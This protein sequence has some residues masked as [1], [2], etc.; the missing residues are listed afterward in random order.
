M[1][2][3]SGFGFNFLYICVSVFTVSFYQF[4][5]SLLNKSINLFL[6]YWHQ[7][8][9][10]CP[11]LRQIKV[12]N[13]VIHLRWLETLWSMFL[14]PFAEN[15]WE[16]YFQK[17]KLEKFVIIA[18]HCTLLYCVFFGLFHYLCSRTVVD[19]RKSLGGK[20]RNLHCPH[21]PHSSLSQSMC[22]GVEDV[23]QGLLF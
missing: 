8:F 22:Y 11:F 1:V 13:A 3:F 7:S 4:N 6:N 12:F 14:H 9:G 17:P 5:T 16:Q 20:G 2:L 18:L 10:W 21:E 15:E 19:E 23:F